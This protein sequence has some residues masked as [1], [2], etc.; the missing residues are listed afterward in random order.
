MQTLFADLLPPDVHQR[1]S[2]ATFDE[3]FWGPH[4]RAI[5]HESLA[6]LAEFDAVDPELLR[7]A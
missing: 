4:S 5:A 1:S 3:A 2:K 6:E 7:A